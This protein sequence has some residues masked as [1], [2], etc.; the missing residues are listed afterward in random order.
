MPVAPYPP[1][2]TGGV[3]VGIGGTSSTNMLVQEPGCRYRMYITDASYTD[4]LLFTD[5]SIYE[6]YKGCLLHKHVDIFTDMS[7]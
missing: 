6:V 5:M 4:M 1:I 3:D 2:M 7:V